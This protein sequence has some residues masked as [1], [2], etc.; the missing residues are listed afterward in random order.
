MQLVRARQLNLK[1]VLGGPTLGVKEVH[2]AHD[3]ELSLYS[4]KIAAATALGIRVKGHKEK[5]EIE[6]DS[7]MPGLT[8]DPDID[9]ELDTTADHVKS[10]N[11]R[12]PDGIDE[13]DLRVR[14]FNSTFK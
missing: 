5:E 9:M 8:E 4:F 3:K 1:V 7:D 6:V 13:T 14:D 10:I 12:F 2:V 11:D